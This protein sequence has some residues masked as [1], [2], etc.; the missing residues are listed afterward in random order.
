MN[1]EDF[2]NFLDLRKLTRVNDNKYICSCP[3]CKEGTHKNRKRFSIFKGY[4]ENWIV[5]CLNCGYNKSFLNYLREFHYDQYERYLFHY[6]TE[7]RGMEEKKVDLGHFRN[8]IDFR[9]ILNYYPVLSGL[10]SEHPAVQY[11]K[12]RQMPD[13][14]FDKLRFCDSFEGLCSIIDQFFPSTID[15]KYTGLNFP[16]IMIPIND[17]DGK[18][19]YIQVRNLVASG[20]YRDMRY[21]T[22]KLN[23]IARK[24]WN[25]DGI[26]PDSDVFVFEGVLDA[27]YINNSVAMLGS[28][29]ADLP[30]YIDRENLIF[31]VDNEYNTS[32]MQ[33]ICNDILDAGCRLV[34]WSIDNRCKD[35]ND[36][37]V[38]GMTTVDGAE[39][40]VRQF[41][42]SGVVA[43][44]DISMRRKH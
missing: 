37:I 6:K 21:M 35:L 14:V 40:F 31:V 11:L 1:I 34:I 7:N 23:K 17:L 38:N 18:L 22:I 27:V 28:A 29:I 13:R 19:S 2:I 42:K 5:R 44:L 32:E 9:S 20:T 30:S 4:D 41:I 8:D 43:R 33:K 25:L 39:E 12:R 15:F 24:I 16:C 3:I 26:D 10:S 36:M